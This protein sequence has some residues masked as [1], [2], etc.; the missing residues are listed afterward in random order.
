MLQTDEHVAS[1]CMCRRCSTVVT[2]TALSSDEG[3]L[4]RVDQV[5]SIKACRDTYQLLNIK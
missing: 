4:L 2:I 5:D 3:Q 1:M